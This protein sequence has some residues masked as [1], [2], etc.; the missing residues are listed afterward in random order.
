MVRHYAILICLVGSMPVR[1]LAQGV[2]PALVVD[3]GVQ[4]FRDASYEEAI[5]L[6]STVDRLFDAS[7]MPVKDKARA[8]FYL[9]LSYAADGAA[10]RASETFRA[11]YELDLTFE[12]S[13][14]L[15][16]QLVQMMEFEKAAATRT[17]CPETACV[18]V[19]DALRSGR[20]REGQ[21]NPDCPCIDDAV[22]AAVTTA[23]QLLVSRDYTEAL[24]RAA[25]LV[26]LRPDNAE[27]RLVA[28][29]ARTGCEV[30]QRSLYEQWEDHFNQRQYAEARRTVT[31]IRS[32]CQGGFLDLL[33]QI[34]ERY[35]SALATQVQ[36]W[37]AA[38]SNVDLPGRERRNEYDAA[39]E[40][41]AALDDGRGINAAA[42]AAT[43]DSRCDAQPC[44]FVVPYEGIV[45]KPPF[46]APPGNGVV[47]VS[48]QLDTQG[49]IVR[50]DD[51]AWFKV[52]A[53]DEDF[54]EVVKEFL[55]QS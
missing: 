1:A 26:D 33:E 53:E 19:L 18:D 9:A 42:L 45:E 7:A 44:E 47:A 41:I 31:E 50:P 17:V 35:Q 49:Q 37:Q 3:E 28:D 5:V 15:P 6:L 21:L 23:Q 13:E 4:Y 36:R 11:L 8:K 51:P 30:S 32:R 12:P 22:E 10:D 55:F 43:E 34:S 2:E 38:C 29:L 46:R 14:Q 16:D 39:G 25:P 52:N 27:A 20:F 24:S 48:F 40:E 54:V